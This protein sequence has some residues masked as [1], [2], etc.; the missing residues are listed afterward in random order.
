MRGSTPQLRDGSAT[1]F[2][3]GG[4]H[5]GMKLITF[6]EPPSETGLF[7]AGPLIGLW[8]GAVCIQIL[9]SLKWLAMFAQSFKTA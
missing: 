9:R 5:F 2:I 8:Y 6:P 7:D 4:L 3:A 1:G